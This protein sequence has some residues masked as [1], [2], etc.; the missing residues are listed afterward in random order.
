MDIFKLMDDEILLVGQGGGMMS[1]EALSGI[2]R[3]FE[4]YGTIPGLARTS[5]GSTLF[6]S[7]YYSGLDS[8][9]FYN[10]ME[11]RPVS[12]FFSVSPIGVARTAVSKGRH[13]FNN[14]GVKKTL[15]QYMTGYAT[16]RV[17]TS[18]TRLLDW[19]QVSMPATPASA[20]AAT[21]IPYIFKPVMIDDVLYVDGGVVNNIPVPDMDEL[22]N[23]K[24][25][26]VFLCPDNTYN[27][28]TEDKLLPGLL[29]LL[30][31][32]MERELKELVYQEYFNQPNVTLI[33]PASNCGGGLL[34]WSPEFKLRDYCYD[35][36]KEILS[37]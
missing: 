37:K 26:Y 31:A 25:V 3:A 5:S 14:D 17:T 19:E 7:L 30:S 12:E 15:E 1:V 21:S 9:W 6:S 34:N 22:K 33:K 24:H 36:T 8:S 4:E 29:E 35:L 13:L 10:L 23:F 28:T 18:L 2:M 32:V 27:D 16:L 20:L 11:N